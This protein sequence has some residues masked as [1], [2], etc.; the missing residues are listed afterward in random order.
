MQADDAAA[1]DQ[2]LM[3]EV[4]QGST[5]AFAELVARHNAGLIN[6]FY[7][8]LRD[9]QLAEDFAQEVLVRLFRA[10]ESYSPE[11]KFTTFLYRIA[12]NYLIDHF[13]SQS[14]R[15]HPLSLDGATGAGEDGPGGEPTRLV[16]VLPGK[17]R[18]PESP[19]ESLELGELIMDAIDQLP[20]EHRMV[21]L[22][23]EVEEMRYQD[24][25]EA[26]EIPV[27]TV[28]SRMHT[29]YHRLRELLKELGPYLDE[30]EE[31]S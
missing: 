21:F 4:K 18:A 26:L 28:K 12:K 24:I 1:I 9:R 15:P 22:M 29:A 10:A 6:F 20:L 16:D 14:I 3:L 2:A 27:G 17:G 11:A 19:L 31:E 13:R 8:S 25:A 23:S 7:R 5:E 30:I